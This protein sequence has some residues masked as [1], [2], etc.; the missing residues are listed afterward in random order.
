[1][2]TYR[3]ED[4]IERCRRG[5]PTAKYRYEEQ[6]ARGTKDRCRACKTEQRR[7]QRLRKANHSQGWVDAQQRRQLEAEAESDELAPGEPEVA[8]L[9]TVYSEIGPVHID[10]AKLLWKTGAARTILERHGTT[11]SDFARAIGTHQTTVSHWLA[12][13]SSP[14]PRVA[15]DATI[16]LTTIREENDEQDQVLKA[17][18]YPATLAGQKQRSADVDAGRWCGGFINSCA[19]CAKI[20]HLAAANDAYREHVRL[21]GP[22]PDDDEPVAP[23]EPESPSEGDTQVT[24]DQDTAA[25]PNQPLPE[26]AVIGPNGQ[27]G[28]R[29]IPAQSL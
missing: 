26:G 22:F 21:Y 28:H 5:H 29:I 25:S 9:R 2:Y 20:P 13:D 27:V 11:A 10:A 15:R 1:M 17:H 4:G 8:L 24:A 3:G 14:S 16:W 18:G 7:K 23:S 6:S 19:V 12:G